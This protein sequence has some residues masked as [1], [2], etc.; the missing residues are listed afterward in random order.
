MTCATGGL[1]WDY[2]AGDF[3][4]LRDLINLTG[5]NSFM[6]PH[7]PELGKDYFID[8]GKPF[9]DR[10][11]DLLLESTRA[12]SDGV[13]N[14]HPE[15]GTYMG[16]LGPTFETPA[17]V[18][19][20]RTIGGDVAGMSTVCEVETAAHAGINVGGLTLVTNLGTGMQA[21][22]NHGEVLRAAKN[23]AGTFV[24]ILNTFFRKYFSQSERKSKL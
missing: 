7:H 3:V 4:V 10:L 6:G 12:H 17:M 11:S 5:Q 15:G 21:E 16:V 1:N 13:F 2:S 14:V 24:Q 20:L 23:S 22:L 8:M 19:Y 18:K 9:C